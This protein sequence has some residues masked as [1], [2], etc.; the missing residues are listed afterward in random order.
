MSSQSKYRFAFT[1]IELL[2]VT[3]I[4]AM[5]S[6]TFITVTI[7]SGDSLLYD[8]IST[9]NSSKAIAMQQAMSSL[10]NGVERGQF[11]TLW[12]A[13]LIKTEV[14]ITPLTSWNYTINAAAMVR[15]NIVSWDIDDLLHPPATIAIDS[16]SAADVET[17]STGFKW[18]TT[19]SQFTGS[20]H[21]TLFNGKNYYLPGGY[22]K[23]SGGTVNLNIAE[24][25]GYMIWVAQGVKDNPYSGWFIT[26]CLI[27]QRARGNNIRV[28]LY[29]RNGDNTQ[30]KSGFDIANPSNANLQLLS[31]YYVEYKDIDINGEKLVQRVMEQTVMPQYNAQSSDPDQLYTNVYLLTL[32]YVY[33]LK[34]RTVGMARLF[35]GSPMITPQSLGVSNYPQVV[36]GGT[37]W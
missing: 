27:I 21:H 9:I 20:V 26:G 10:I 2:A 19:S 29:A 11:R 3:L 30:V 13:G 14:F 33:D 4:M 15:N 32:P 25:G 17:V 7:R 23:T 18:H 1:S 34:A 31:N 36:I 37:E 28:A 35:T 22:Y 5:V 24:G 8:S 6:A 12:P 16:I